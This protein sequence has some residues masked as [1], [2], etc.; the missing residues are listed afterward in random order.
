MVAWVSVV[1]DDEL[2]LIIGFVSCSAILDDLQSL[3]VSRLIDVGM[4]SDVIL[5][6]VY[7]DSRGEDQHICVK[8]T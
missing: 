7:V 1:W 6:P 5:S 2:L 8:M 4:K 3:L